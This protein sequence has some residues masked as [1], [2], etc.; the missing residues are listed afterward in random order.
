MAYP[1]AVIR[2]A[3]QILGYGITDTPGARTYPVIDGVVYTDLF[4]GDATITGYTGT[5]TKA[6]NSRSN[7][8]TYWNELRIDGCTLK[9]VTLTL[10]WGSTAFL[11]DIDGL[12]AWLETNSTTDNLDEAG[13]KSKKIEDFSVTKGTAEETSADINLILNE[14]FGYYIRRILLLDVA[15]EQKDASRYF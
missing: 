10:T 4:V 2:R 5:I 6:F 13:V 15:K 12:L 1:N 11:A 3:E 14:G 9:E 7:A 8:M